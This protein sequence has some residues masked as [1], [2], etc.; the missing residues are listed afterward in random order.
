MVIRGISALSWS[1]WGSLEQ[2]YRVIVLVFHEDLLATNAADNLVAEPDSGPSKSLD[3]GYQVI[4][5][6]D[7]AIPTP[8][9]QPRVRRASV[10]APRFRDR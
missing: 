5:L 8:P 7:D 3:G 10:C 6:D 2:L 9:A 4:D 1:V